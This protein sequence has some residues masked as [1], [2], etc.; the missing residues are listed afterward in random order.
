MLSTDGRCKAFDESADGYVRSEA[1]SVVF[2]QKAKDA[3]RVY[4]TLVHSKLNCDGFKEQGVTFPSSRMQSVLL[5][6]FYLEC[7]IPPSLV[8]YVEAHGTGT[9]VGDPEEVN[10]IDKIF[11]P[12]RKTPLKIGSG[13][14]NF[15]HSEPASGLCSVA[16]V[17]TLFEPT[18][19]LL[20]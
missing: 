11:T 1:V 10:A 8:D 13:K 15:G 6:E 9:R 4:A 16:K 12:G 19:H 20:I 18:S 7:G 5:K 17:S 14:S 3:K 2:L